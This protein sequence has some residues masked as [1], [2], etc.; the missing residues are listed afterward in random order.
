MSF[1]PTQ[2]RRIRVVRALS[3]RQPKCRKRSASSHERASSRS[4][5]RRYRSV[6]ERT[7]TRQSEARYRRRKQARYPS[8]DQES[9]DDHGPPESR[10]YSS[11]IVTTCQTHRKS[12]LQWTID[13]T[14]LRGQLPFQPR[15]PLGKNPSSLP[16]S[17]RLPASD[18]LE[19][20][21]HHQVILQ[22]F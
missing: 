1:Q 17:F 5:H 10:P 7:K 21:L 15:F 14:L 9:E 11:P 16:D 8:Q 13:A 4:H 6:L 22:A 3:L 12:C 18:G 20:C 2:A 19:D